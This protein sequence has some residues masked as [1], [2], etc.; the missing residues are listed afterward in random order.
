MKHRSTGVPS[1][2]IPW[3]W[4]R[5][6][7]DPPDHGG[8][9]QLLRVGV[10]NSGRG[11]TYPEALSGP[12]SPGHTNPCQLHGR[13]RNR[14]ALS[15]KLQPR[16]PAP[17]VAFVVN[18]NEFVA[19]L[20]HHDGV[21]NLPVGLACVKKRQDAV[22]LE[23]G[24]AKGH[25]LE[26]VG[27]AFGGDAAEPITAMQYCGSGQM[28]ARRRTPKLHKFCREPPPTEEVLV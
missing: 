23:V 27:K 19:V 7:P 14:G 28:V 2:I 10:R 17:S 3:S 13:M 18:E 1:L 25:S 12:L 24:K 8:V 4:V 6:P 26:Q 5:S 22:V 9:P 21:E 15:G 16:P 11:A 20:L